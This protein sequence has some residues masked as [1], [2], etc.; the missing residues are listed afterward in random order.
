M[1]FLKRVSVVVSTYSRERSKHL[2]DCIE[3]VNKQSLKPHEVILV[4]DPNPNL[5]NFYKTKVPANTKIV[6]SQ[7][8]GL[9]NAR[10]TGIDYG[11]GEIIAF[12]DDDAVAD[13]KWLENLVKNYADPNVV[14]VGGLTKP[15]WANGNPSWFPEELNWVV[16]CSYKGHPEFKANVRNPIGCNMSFRKSVFEKVGCFRPDLGRF[17]KRL[18]A[19]EEAELSMRIHEKIPNSKIIYEPSAVVHHKVTKKRASLTYVWKRSFY[20]GVS[21]ALIANGKEDSLHALSTESKY[22]NYLFK[23]AIPSRIR[24]FYSLTS[25][26]QLVMLLYSLSAVFLGFSSGKLRGNQ[27][28][29]KY[30]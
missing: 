24:N 29:P 28:K 26:R 19:S 27:S 13:R 6:L 25:L 10:N 18:L 16:G 22:L 8:S 4:L 20:E 21:K 9:S 3:S 14:G 1:R 30:N 5:V 11:E 17:G 12:I 23:V 2:L 15:L 7:K